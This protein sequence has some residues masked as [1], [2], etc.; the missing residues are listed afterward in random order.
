VNELPTF[1]KV[2]IVIVNWERPGDTIHCIRSVMESDYPNIEIVL[3]DNG[4]GDNSVSQIQ[5]SCDQLNIVELP[6]NLGFTGGYNTGIMKALE[7]DA[8]FVFLLNNDTIIEKNTI[9]QLVTTSWDI[10]VP[11]ITFHDS[12]NMIWAAG[13]KW[14]SFPPTIKMIGYKKPDGPKYNLRKELEYATGCAL[15]IRREVLHQ[16]GGFDERYVNY[17]EDYDFTYRAREA[18]F[19]IGYVPAAKVLHKVSS[20]LGESSPQRWHYLGRNT[21]LFYRHPGRFPSVL[22]WLVLGWNIIREIINGHAGCIPD[23]WS[24]VVEGFE[25]SKGAS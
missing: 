3:V 7:L 10:S 9:S 11:K 13:A 8:G 15:M 22:I 4:S 21:V 19:T 12:P 6:K 2:V 18:G 24:G 25:I 5:G 17:L 14:R 1:E 20:S 16:I 23:F